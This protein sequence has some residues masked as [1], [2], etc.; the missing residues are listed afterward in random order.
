MYFAIMKNNEILESELTVQ[1][2]ISAEV[3]RRLKRCRRWILKLISISAFLK[4]FRM[5]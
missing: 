4:T 1:E 2:E 5:L 3:F